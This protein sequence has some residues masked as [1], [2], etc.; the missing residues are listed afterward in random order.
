MFYLPPLQSLTIAYMYTIDK[1]DYPFRWEKSTFVSDIK[2]WKDYFAERT[3]LCKLIKIIIIPPHNTYKFW[4][5]NK[6]MKD[7]SRSFGW[8]S[9][10]SEKCT[11]K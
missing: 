4:K 8:D 10:G 3:L 1:L 6:P 11:L 2:V 9:L 7:S 5:K